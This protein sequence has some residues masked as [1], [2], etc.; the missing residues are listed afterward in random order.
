M[1]NRCQQHLALMRVEVSKIRSKETEAPQQEPSAQ[2]QPTF[3]RY[4]LTLV[5]F[6]FQKLGFS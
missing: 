2:I 1:D 4:K 3:S 5:Y 6:F